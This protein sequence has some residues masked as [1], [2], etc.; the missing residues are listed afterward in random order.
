MH[1]IFAILHFSKNGWGKSFPRSRELPF[2]DNLYK[3][4]E[5]YSTDNFP[6]LA[7]SLSG[8]GG[9]SKRWRSDALHQFLRMLRLAFPP[10]VDEPIIA[11]AVEDRVD[12]GIQ[13]PVPL[14]RAHR[15]QREDGSV[16]LEGRHCFGLPP[17][18]SQ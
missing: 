10:L 14:R 18:A 8:C 5:Q 6:A 13:P 17:S 2:H 12:G 7:T 16:S 1:P 11:C 4:F 3:D 9:G 15:A